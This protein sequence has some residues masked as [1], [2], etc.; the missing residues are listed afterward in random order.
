MAKDRGVE[1]NLIS[2][3]GEECKLEKLCPIVEKT[4]GEVLKVDPEKL[5]EN[6]ANILE[7]PIIAT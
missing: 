5:T 1:V 6:F 4:Y 2:I 7:S 3:E